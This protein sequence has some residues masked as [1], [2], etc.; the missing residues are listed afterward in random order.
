MGAATRPHH[1]LAHYPHH[2]CYS[3]QRVRLTAGRWGDVFGYLSTIHTGGRIAFS[4]TNSARAE[5]GLPARVNN[6]CRLWQSRRRWRIRSKPQ[7]EGL[8]GYTTWELRRDDGC[9]EGSGLVLIRALPNY[10]YEHAPP[11]NGHSISE[12]QLNKW[13]TEAEIGYD[14]K[15]LHH[16]QKKPRLKDGAKVASIRLS[17]RGKNPR[18]G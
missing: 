2:A 8:Q 4:Q 14:V 6:C 15:M 10:G 16:Q 9:S 7:D 13:V 18:Q 17:R 3:P 12:G 1:R 5:Y 11:T